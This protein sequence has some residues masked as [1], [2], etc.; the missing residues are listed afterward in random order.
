MLDAF[1][2]IPFD[3]VDGGAWKQG[4]AISYSEAQFE[5]QPLKVFVVP[6]S[7]CDPGK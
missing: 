3:N 2:E 1:D 5:N 7:H 6:Q 4:F